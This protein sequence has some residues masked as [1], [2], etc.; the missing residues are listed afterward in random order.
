MLSEEQQMGLE[1]IESKK[2]TVNIQEPTE[3]NIN[4]R[5]NS[6][7]KD[8]EENQD[9]NENE[10]E[11]ENENDNENELET[12]QKIEEIEEQQMIKLSSDDLTNV[13]DNHEKEYLKEE[14]SR[15][16]KI[17]QALLD[18]QKVP[19]SYYKNSNKELLITQY[20]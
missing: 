8:E 2:S 3:Q 10:I 1:N 16:E 9:E 12:E 13:L 19:K 6:Q 5:E 18:K 7:D 4:E 11:G 20:M 17:R 14:A 15:K